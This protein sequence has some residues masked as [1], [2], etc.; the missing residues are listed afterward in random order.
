MKELFDQIDRDGNGTVSIDE[1][2]IWSLGFI[3]SHTGSGLEAIFRKYDKDGGG[4]LDP[5]EFDM[6]AEDLG[7]GGISNDLFVELDRNNSGTV[8]A[9]DLTRYI[10][11]IGSSRDAKRF[12]TTLAYED[13]RVTLDTSSWELAGDS[14]EALREQVLARVLELSMSYL[15]ASLELPLSFLETHPYTQTHPPTHL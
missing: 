3:S 15:T 7:F 9:T 4:V 2:F 12:L 6:V 14:A 10:G 11:S 13:G 1:F 5:A 8:S